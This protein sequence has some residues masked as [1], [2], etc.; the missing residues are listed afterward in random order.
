MVLVVALLLVAA[1]S[2]ATLQLLCA[3]STAMNRPVLCTDSRTAAVSNGL[4]VRGS[5]TSTEIPSR[6]RIL[7]VLS[8]EGVPA[9]E[10][11]LA[12]L[13][14]DSVHVIARCFEHE[15]KLLLRPEHL[16]ENATDK[17]GRCNPEDE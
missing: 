14:D 12:V 3:G 5:M 7:E 11:R 13:G 15:G 8:E 2:L 6:A 4:I 10:E 17:Q 1:I 9:T 16:Q